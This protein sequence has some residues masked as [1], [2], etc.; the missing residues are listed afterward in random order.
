MYHNVHVWVKAHDR[1]DRRQHPISNT[2]FVADFLC[3]ERQLVIE[4]D[5]DIHGTQESEDWHRQQAIEN[6]GYRVIRFTNDQIQNDLENVLITILSST[7]SSPPH[8]EGE[9]AGG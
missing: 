4:L 3:Y 8:P 6:A 5:G 7:S 9:G 1:R 2:T